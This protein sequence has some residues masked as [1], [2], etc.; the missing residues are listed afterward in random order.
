MK[1]LVET[2]LAKR[3][4]KGAKIGATVTGAL[5]GLKG[6]VKTYKYFRKKDIGPKAK[7]VHTLIGTGL[8]GGGGA[9]TGAAIGGAAGAAYHGAEKLK[10]MLAARRAKRMKKK[11]KQESNEIIALLVDNPD[12]I[13]DIVDALIRSDV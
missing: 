8:H 10:K 2:T 11:R 3:I 13:S 7:L 12:A 9:V 6:G 4:K 1:K 5:K